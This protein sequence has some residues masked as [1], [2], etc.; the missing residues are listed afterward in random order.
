MRKQIMCLVFLGLGCAEMWEPVDYPFPGS[1]GA[2]HTETEYSSTEYSPTEHSCSSDYGCG[3]GEACVKPQYKSTGKCMRKV[4][5]Y[6]VTDYSSPRPDSAGIRT[7]P[8]CNFDTQCPI[9]FK[10]VSGNCVR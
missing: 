1:G 6:G 4:N 5:K 3:P 9:G 10:C 7:S 2:K 8:D